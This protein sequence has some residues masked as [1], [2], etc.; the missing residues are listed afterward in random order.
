[1]KT[2]LVRYIPSSFPGAQWKR[3]GLLWREQLS[4]LS[5]VP[6]RWAKEQ[7]V[8]PHQY[9]SQ[10]YLFKNVVLLDRPMEQK[11]NHSFLAFS[12]T[13]RKVHHPRR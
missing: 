3:Q 13:P 6:Y 12:M 10:I 2:P 9:R 5:A 11:K 7:M 8:C 4:H 1:M